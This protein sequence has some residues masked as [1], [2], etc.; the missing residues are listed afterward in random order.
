MV[1]PEVIIASNT[2]STSI[3]KLAA[4]AGRDDR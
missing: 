2:S 3:T 1:G 4:V